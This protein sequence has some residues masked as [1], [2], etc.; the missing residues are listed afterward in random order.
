MD[1]STSHGHTE[2]PKQ[3]HRFFDDLSPIVCFKSKK[4]VDCKIYCRF[5]IRINSALTFFVSQIYCFSK[6]TVQLNLNCCFYIATKHRKITQCCFNGGPASKT[7]VQHW[8]S[9][10]WMTR[11]CWAITE[12]MFQKE[13]TPITQASYTGPLL[14]PFVTIIR[15]L[16][17]RIWASI[18]TVNITK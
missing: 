18:G 11:V 6:F 4:T 2:K 10:G 13:I 8:N 9:I 16:Y 3:N 15:P 1:T 12:C 7:L 17:N 14:I 5:Q